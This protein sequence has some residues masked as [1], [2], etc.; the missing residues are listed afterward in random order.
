MS[1]VA[2]NFAAFFEFFDCD[3]YYTVV[4]LCAHSCTC[5]EFDNLIG[6]K[7]E[8]CEYLIYCVECETKTNANN[9]P[10]SQN[11]KR[12]SRSS[13]SCC[14]VQLSQSIAKQGS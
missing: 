7:Y 2:F 8:I 9:P 14:P 6:K 3:K 4:L 11:P 10:L 1:L 12:A 5:N 13:S